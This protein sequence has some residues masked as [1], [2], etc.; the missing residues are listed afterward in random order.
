MFVFVRNARENYPG[1]TRDWLAKKRETMISNSRKGYIK[2]SP[3]GFA[4]WTLSTNENLGS[5]NAANIKKSQDIRIH[6][7]QRSVSISGSTNITQDVSDGEN[8]TKKA[9]GAQVIEN[10]IW[11]QLI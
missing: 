1:F 10:L 7:K 11:I 4:Q 5:R 9:K 6:C 8:K 2:I 3:E